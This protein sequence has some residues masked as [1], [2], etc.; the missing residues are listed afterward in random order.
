[1][2][3]MLNRLVQAATD[4]APA[5]DSELLDGF[6]TSHSEPAF[7]SLVRR[8]GPMV[9]AVCRRVLRHREDAEDAFQATFLILARRAADVWPRDAVGSWLYGVAHRVAL[10]ARTVRARRLTREQPLDENP[11]ATSTELPPPD[12]AEVIDRAVRKL[13]EVY[14]VAVVACDL[15][16]LTRKAAAEQLGWK[17]GTLSGRLARARQLLASRLRKAGLVLPAGG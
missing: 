5:T 1:M 2:D 7:E 11:P 12:L 4:P 17:E 6:L 8:H 9:L 15:E 13:P 16:G 14:R 10:K 3:R